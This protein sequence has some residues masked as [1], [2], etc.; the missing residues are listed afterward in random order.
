VLPL[1]L[2]LGQP[3]A[4][5]RARETAAR[6]RQESGATI[7]LSI[8]VFGGFDE[9][10]VLHGMAVVAIERDGEEPDVTA[11]GLRAT[12]EDVHRRSAMHAADRLRR[13]LATRAEPARH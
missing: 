13:L 5:A 8:V 6:V 2:S 1:D 9:R 3:D 12:I 11:V 10:K 7:G 4:D